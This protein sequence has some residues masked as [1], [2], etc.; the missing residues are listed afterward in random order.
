MKSIFNGMNLILTGNGC[1]I[2]SEHIQHLPKVREPNLS[3]AA[4]SCDKTL[5]V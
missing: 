1:R 5:R 3:L 2:E 4:F